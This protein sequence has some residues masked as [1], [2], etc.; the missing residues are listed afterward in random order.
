MRVVP[1]VGLCCNHSPSPPP[2]RPSPH[3]ATVHTPSTASAQRLHTQHT[4]VGDNVMLIGNNEGEDF[5]MKFGKISNRN[6]YRPK[7]WSTYVQTTFDRT[8]GSS[9]SPVLNSKYEVRGCSSSGAV[10]R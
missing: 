3:R 2:L 9:G 4:Q 6:R 1:R 10:V 7:E 8:G 5:T